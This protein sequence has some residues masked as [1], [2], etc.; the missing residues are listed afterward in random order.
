[1]RSTLVCAVIRWC[2]SRDWMCIDLHLCLQCFLHRPVRTGTLLAHTPVCFL[3]PRPDGEWSGAEQWLAGS[4][5]SGGKLVRPPQ[6]GTHIRPLEQPRSSGQ[7]SGLPGRRHLGG[8]RLG[9]VL[10][11][12]S[13]NHARSL[14]YLFLLRCA[15]SRHGS[16]Q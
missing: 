7:H 13:R 6:T 11:S 8:H 14:H 4:H 2:E 1:M 12:S 3:P 9:N 5:V 16:L 15:L 10:F